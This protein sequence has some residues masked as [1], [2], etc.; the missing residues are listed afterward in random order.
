MAEYARYHGAD[1]AG[2]WVLGL[3]VPAQRAALASGYSFCEGPAAAV[4]KA[5]DE[6]WRQSDCYEVM[7]QPLAYYGE[8]SRREE[9]SARWPLL[10]RWSARAACWPHADSLSGIYAA[11]LE[12]EPERVLPALERW[13]R[14][15]PPWRRRI[16]VVS[17]IYYSSQRERVLPFETLL[18]LLEAQVEVD[19]LY[20]QKGLGWALRE[21]GNVYP[22]RT[23][24][25]LVQ[26]APR[27][28]AAAFAS[29]SEK[30]GPAEREQLKALRRGRGR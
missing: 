29:A 20:V 27:L 1:V 26:N 11:L 21:L 12:R 23:W 19:H 28:S 13:S 8:R 25:W 30:R 4:A 15:R 10:L 22:E 14:G 7:S 17:L 18:P 9:L 16:G 6:V 5:W 2:L 3:K 24:A